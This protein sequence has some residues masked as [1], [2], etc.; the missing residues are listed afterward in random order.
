MPDRSFP[1][2]TCLIVGDSIL[3]GIGENRLKSGKQKIK[4]RH[5]P[6]AHTDDMFRD[7]TFMT[8]MKN[9]QFLHSLPLFLSVRM[10]P[11]W[12]SPRPWTLKLREP[13]SLPIPIPFG[14]LAAY[15]LY[16]VDV[17]IIYHACAAYNSAT[18]NQFKLNSIF[19]SKTQ[20]NT[21]HL[22]CLKQN[23]VPVWNT[24]RN[25]RQQSGRL[26]RTRHLSGTLF[27]L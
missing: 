14:I 6:G 20:A 4:L 11:I 13:T 24:Y 2:G 1:K 3:A 22:E 8:S 19:C 17:S 18:K 26:S 10:G 5:F 23:Q 25:T 27:G 15:R 12:G 21:S 16:L 7:H 9:V